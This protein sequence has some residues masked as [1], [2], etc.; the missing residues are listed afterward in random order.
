MGRPR[1]GHA[2]KENTAS[3]SVFHAGGGPVGVPALLDKSATQPRKGKPSGQ[4]G[5]NP[6]QPRTTRRG[7]SRPW[8]NLKPTENTHRRHEQPPRRKPR[9]PST[10]GPPCE[11]LGF[12]QRGTLDNHK[13]DIKATAFAPGHVHSARAPESGLNR[14]KKLPHERFTPL[15]RTAYSEDEARCS[16]GDDSV[17]ES[18]STL[19]AESD[20]SSSMAFGSDV[21]DDS[22]GFVDSSRSDIRAVADNGLPFS[23]I[24]NEPTTDAGAKDQPV[25]SQSAAKRRLGHRS[26]KPLTTVPVLPHGIS[27]GLPIPNHSQPKQRT[28]YRHSIRT[29]IKRVSLEDYEANEDEDREISW[30]LSCDSGVELCETLDETEGDSMASA[31]GPAVDRGAYAGSGTEHREASIMNRLSQRYLSIGDA[32]QSV[33]GVGVRSEPPDRVDGLPCV[34]SSMSEPSPEYAPAMTVANLDASAFAREFAANEGFSSLRDFLCS[35]TERPP[36]PP[37]VATSKSEDR[38][39]ASRSSVSTVDDATNTFDTFESENATGTEGLEDIAR[40][41]EP[42]FRAPRCSVRGPPVLTSA[43][44]ELA[45]GDSEHRLLTNESE[46]PTYPAMN[47]GTRPRKNDGGSRRFV[48]LAVRDESEEVLDAPPEMAQHP[49]IEPAL[50]DLQRASIRAGNELA[51]A[52]FTASTALAHGARRESQVSRAHGEVLLRG[53]FLRMW[54]K[55]Y[56][57]VVDHAYFGAVLFLFHAVDGPAYSKQ[58]HNEDRSLVLRNSKMIVLAD[59]NVQE[60]DVRRKNRTAFLFELSTSQRKYVFACQSPRQRAYWVDNLTRCDS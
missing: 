48:D 21:Q 16:S 47:D 28:T 37:E 38:L 49:G 41:P 4:G 30:R 15:L 52:A 54:T 18:E 10:Y 24:G 22:L 56:A 57:S 12:A 42:S 26:I 7:E 55:R 5:E 40:Q 43:P 35:D 31:S 25:A 17:R 59:T 20:S 23:N 9:E 13:M 46:K 32:T 34:E 8:D 44:Q 53:R 11:A 1:R 29:S 3:P 2:G 60:V 45:V 51:V 27:A 58:Q 6:S 39:S 36:E 14:H 50:R 33:P 19:N